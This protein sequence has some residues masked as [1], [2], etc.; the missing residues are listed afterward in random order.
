MEICGSDRH[1]EIETDE[2]L[3]VAMTVAQPCLDNAPDQAFCVACG[4]LLTKRA[5]GRAPVTPQ[6]HM[7]GVGRKRVSTR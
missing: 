4:K 1:E 6:P 7:I 3:W 2:G 5:D